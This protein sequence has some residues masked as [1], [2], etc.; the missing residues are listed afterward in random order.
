MNSSDIT[1]LAGLRIDGR[2]PDELRT[3][4]TKLG[5]ISKADGSAYYEQ[6]KDESYK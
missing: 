4:N 1:A 5:L 3:I 2:K 6:V